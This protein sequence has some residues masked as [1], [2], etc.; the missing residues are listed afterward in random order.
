MY[1]NPTL[2]HEEPSGSEGVNKNEEKSW[3]PVPPFVSF[4]SFCSNS[5]SASKKTD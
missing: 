5:P 4:V 1:L 3:K 2:F